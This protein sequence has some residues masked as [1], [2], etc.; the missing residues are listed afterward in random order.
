VSRASPGRAAA[1]GLLLAAVLGAAPARAYVRTTDPHT[2]KALSW[3]V[4]LVPWRLD[5]DWPDA[6]PSCQA[7][8]GA[9][10][11][12]DA[13]LASFAQWQQG[14]TDLRLLYAGTLSDLRTGTGANLVL[15]RRGWCSQNAQAVSDPCI[16]DPASNCGNTYGCYDD[17]PTCIGQSSCVQWNIV[18][19][20]SVL[21]DPSNGRIL[22]ADIEVNGWDG[23]GVGNLLS[24]PR[25]GWYFSCI[26]GIVQ[27][28]A[29]TRYG[30]GSPPSAPCA[31]VDLQNT[32]THEVG[33]FIGLRHPC[34]TDPAAEP[35]LQFCGSAVPPGQ[36]PFLQRTMSPT[37]QPR[38]IT[39]RTLSAD[40][41]SAVCDIY[42]ATSGGGCGCGSVGPAGGAALLLAALALRPRRRRA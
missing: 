2:G 13:V 28:T 6:S 4:P 27:P 7:G 31:Y 3:P 8:G 33:H 38:E 29:C 19:L 21:Y 42:P 10:P 23:G 26:P 1:A 17:G 12:L 15:F 22:E 11:V 32:V 18:A 37:T 41:V 35:D 34:T 20:T 5:R 36:V 39:K 24:P 14:C 40:E 30:D 25:H 9:D 16:R